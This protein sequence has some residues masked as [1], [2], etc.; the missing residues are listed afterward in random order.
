[1]FL[2]VYVAWIYVVR[3]HNKKLS[4][5]SQTFCFTH[6]HT[7]THTHIFYFVKVRVFKYTQPNHYVASPLLMFFWRAMIPSYLVFSA[8]KS[9]FKSQEHCNLTS[10]SFSICAW[11][12]EE[13]GGGKVCNFFTFLSM[14]G[15]PY[16]CHIIHT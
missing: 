16:M 5:K 8:T 6:T 14:I 10:T 4:T 7:H 3:W 12:F 2:N 11:G 15:I 1:M 9:L 13:G